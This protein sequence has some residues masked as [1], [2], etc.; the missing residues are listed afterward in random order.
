VTPGDIVLVDWRDALEASG[1]PNKRRPAIVVGEPPYFG[2]GLPFEIVV[3]LTS[4]AALAIPDASLRIAPAPANGCAKLS[5]ALSWNVQTVPHR[6]LSATRS[7]VTSDQLDV[8]RGQVARCI[9]AL[10]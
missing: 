4:E 1:E 6:R 9:G 3:P 10:S 7:R 8:I 2:T 5:Y